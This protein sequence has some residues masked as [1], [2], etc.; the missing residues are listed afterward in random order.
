MSEVF[1]F[2]VSQDTSRLKNFMLTKNITADYPPTLIVQAKNDRLV[3]LPQVEQF[4][5]YLKGIGV[6][7]ELYLV[8]NGHSIQL[9]RDNPDALEKIV[10][11][12]DKYL[13]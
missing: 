1:G 10:S 12:L 2:D 7:S 9:I 3:P 6:K 8:E 4:D 11:F 13:K 5:N